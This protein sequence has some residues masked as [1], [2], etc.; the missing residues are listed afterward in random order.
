MVSATLPTAISAGTPLPNLL[1]N[2]SKA[3]ANSFSSFFALFLIDITFF[4]MSL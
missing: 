1:P 2:W 4:D 3:F